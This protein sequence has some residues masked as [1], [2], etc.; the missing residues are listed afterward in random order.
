MIFV[1]LN[2]LK[3]RDDRGLGVLIKAV[4]FGARL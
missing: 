4:N 2:T 1:S 3:F